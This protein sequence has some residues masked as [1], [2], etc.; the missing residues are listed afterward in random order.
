MTKKGFT[1]IEVILVLAIAGLMLTGLIANISGS[2]SSKRYSTSVQDFDRLLRQV[3]NQVE[4]VQIAER[5]VITG[6][7]N[8]DYCVVDGGTAFNGKTGST[9]GSTSAYNKNTTASGRTG[10]SVYGKLVTFGE[11]TPSTNKD[12]KSI[13]VY[14]VIGDVVD[15]RNPLKST[16]EKNA[17]KEVHLGIIARRGDSNVVSSYSYALDWGA[18]VED[19][20]LNNR[21]VGALLIV[22]SPLSS[23]IHTY[24]HSFTESQININATYASSIPTAGY[25]MSNLD[26]YS[27]SS[28]INFCINSEDRGS[29]KRYNIRLMADAHNAS[30]IVFVSQDDTTAEGNACN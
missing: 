18:W 8:T 25:I 9:L 15:A 1:L 4:N 20:I 2:I 16:D 17:L 13:Y 27:N 21:M 24:Y 26:G 11:G 22:R 30:D 19:T 14:D 6:A 29:A 10:C 23:I 28:N 5:S 12:A 7:A 3:Y